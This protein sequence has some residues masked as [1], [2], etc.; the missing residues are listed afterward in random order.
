MNTSQPSLKRDL[1]L[2]A[3]ITIVVGNMIGSGIFGLPAALASVAPPLITLLAWVVAGVGATIIAL[4]YGNLSR[5]IPQAG[6]PVV[7]AEAAFGTFG[8][9]VVCLVWWIA[10]AVGN[11]AMVDLIFT[12]IVQF[13]PSLNAPIYKIAITLGFLW[14]FTY[15]NIQGVKLTGF[16]S[17]VTTVLK[18]GVFAVI[19]ILA[20]PYLN[21][22]LF[23]DSQNIT[24]V[25]AKEGNS[26]FAMF[27]AS[28]ALI[29]W[30]FAGLESSTL[31]GSEIR[32]PH[33]NIQRS[34]VWGLL[35]VSSVYIIINTSLMALIPQQQ[36]AASSS[37]FADAINFVTGSNIGGKIIDA[38]ILVSVTGALSGW[39]LTTGRSAYAASKD[40]FFIGVFAKVHP[41]HRT[42]HVAL[43]ISSAVTSVFLLLD[44]FSSVTHTSGG[45]SPFI[46]ITTVASFV[47][48]PTYLGTV[49]AEIVLMRRKAIPVTRFAYI[50]LFAALLFA[51][52]FIY[53]GAI[54]SHVP[55]VYWYITILI[56]AMGLA[57]Y[58]FFKRNKQQI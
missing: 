5:S 29:F 6:G 37:P 2:F 42:P 49:L 32:N 41:K 44:Y 7:Y 58:P 34:V 55:A 48:L 17:I 53:F 1:G 9:Y 10:G 57:F 27:S 36:L 16:I 15:T 13:V 47:T 33:K 25:V 19:V 35:I 31:T 23:T 24:P 50:R 18:V 28:M 14:T 45:I 52:V 26:T 39:I 21:F 43:I 51:I 4:S 3:A 56:M 8:G 20:L 38:A 12:Q 22:G 46:N 30:A 54:G 11:A 40:G